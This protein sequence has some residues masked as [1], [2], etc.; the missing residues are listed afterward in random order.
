MVNIKQNKFCICEKYSLPDRGT[1][2]LSSS[3]EFS[4]AYFI[5]IIHPFTNSILYTFIKPSSNT[6]H[7][8]PI[9]TNTV[10]E[11]S[12]VN[13]TQLQIKDNGSGSANV[14]LINI[15]SNL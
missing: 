9:K 12:I 8:T 13:T 3:I 7:L 1:I 6:A 10:F 2:T 15:E 5:T 4:K 11:L 14:Y